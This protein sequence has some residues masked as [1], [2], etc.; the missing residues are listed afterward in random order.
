M[1]NFINCERFTNHL[2]SLR[3]VESAIRVPVIM[4]ALLIVLDELAVGSTPNG[5]GAP[6]PDTLGRLFTEVPDLE[7]PTL[8][9]MGLG[10]ILKGRV[11]DP[12]ARKCT[13][14]YG[15]MRQRSAGSDRISGF[16]EL[17]GAISGCAF[18]VFEQPPK[19]FVE[20][21]TRRCGVEFLV[22][23]NGDQADLQEA[24][25]RTGNPILVFREES[26][27]HFYV[28]ESVC[29]PARLTRI[30]RMVRRVCDDWRVACVV[31]HRMRGN[32]GKWIAAEA[33]HPFFMI[34]PR[35]GLNAVSERGLA[36]EAVG[37]IHE[38]FGH[39]G[40]TRAHP[41]AT[42][43]ESLKTVEQLWDSPQS[44]LI[45]AN[46]PTLANGTST[47]FARRLEALDDWM[48][49]FMEEI[50]NDNLIIL[51]GSNGGPGSFHAETP[52]QEVPVM[53]HYG[54]RNAPLGLRESFADVAA[55]LCAFFGIE[56]R[57]RAWPAGE[58]LIT[59]HRP[60]DFNGPWGR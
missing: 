17:A 35:T 27:V 12:P 7:L 6:C 32:S 31:G 4:R 25:L 5:N 51:A 16:W 56:E 1:V 29:S 44:G 49:R 37:D 18:S 24:H 50:E 20:A 14:S 13:A 60:K 47:E 43:A 3:F 57:G 26:T 36:V 19:E 22:G 23:A 55:T 45:F 52:R 53:L 28:H 10:E 54:G 39:S 41:C 8:F 9:S 21:L 59:F 48:G 34:P 38:I 42:P 11:F 33:P 40:I 46:L 58:R 30:C 15:R 2:L